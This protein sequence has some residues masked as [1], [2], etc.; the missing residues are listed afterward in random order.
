MF[1]NIIIPSNAVKYILLQ[2]TAY[3]V[4]TKTWLYR[5]TNKV[6]IKTGAYK[7]I[8]RLIPWL[9]FNTILM[10]EIF[11]RNKVLIENQFNKDMENEYEDIKPW[12]PGSA[13]V[14]LDIGCGIGGIDVLLHRHY[15]CDPKIAFYL[16]D[17]TNI[18]KRVYYGFE[19]KSAFYNSLDVTEQLLS[20]N[21][22]PRKNIHLLES[23][24]DLRINV[25]TDV[26][27]VISLFSWGFHYPVSTYL[28]QVYNILRQGGHLLMDIR[29]ATGEEKWLEKRFSKVKRIS[30]GPKHIRVLA[31]K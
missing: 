12:L 13:S 18:R 7:I 3:L 8:N 2:R 27:L 21:G 28:D 26:A 25:G 30:E 31:V 15:N 5:I 10:M 6:L 11:I 29:K 19:E 22:I 23:T 20:Q 24:P 9:I 16:L 4:L 17:K 1:S 14:I